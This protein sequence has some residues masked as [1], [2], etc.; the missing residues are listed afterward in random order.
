MQV[1]RRLAHARG[2]LELDMVAEAAAE[3]AFIPEPENDAMEVVAIRLAVLQEQ[4]NWPALSALAGGFVRRS[5]DHAAGWVTWAYATRRA[6]SLD[7]AEKILVEAERYH[8][9]EPTIQFNLGCYACQRGD[10]ATARTR[11]ERAIA[12]DSKFAEAAAIDPDLAPLRREK[13]RDK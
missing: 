6:D 13:R 1:K 7:A 5:P 10:L 11:V 8:P 3:L 2:Y 4:K 12:L 9:A